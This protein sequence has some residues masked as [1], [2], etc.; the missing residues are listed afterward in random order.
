[1]AKDAAV[2]STT[3]FIMTIPLVYGS[4]AFR[5]PQR[6]SNRRATPPSSQHHLARAVFTAARF[7]DALTALTT[8][9]KSACIT[10]AIDPFQAS[11]ARIARIQPWGPRR[12]AVFETTVPESGLRRSARRFRAVF[13]KEPEARL[14]SNFIQNVANRG[15]SDTRGARSGGWVAILG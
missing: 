15:Q 14:D 13:C 10:C 8:Q 3:I 5:K 4:I 7:N 9:P 12:I 11:V 1:M 2:A 6:W